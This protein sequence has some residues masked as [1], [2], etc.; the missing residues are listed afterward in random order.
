MTELFGAALKSVYLLGFMSV[1]SSCLILSFRVFFLGGGSFAFAVYLLYL[2]HVIHNSVNAQ[3][4]KQ[5]GLQK[6]VCTADSV[7]LYAGG[8]FRH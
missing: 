2:I 7:T 4:R 5:I 1:H 3:Q 8:F 6:L